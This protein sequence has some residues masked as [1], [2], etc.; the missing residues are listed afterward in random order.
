MGVRLKISLERKQKSSGDP[1]E[2]MKLKLMKNA[3]AG[4]GSLLLMFTLSG[5]TAWAVTGGEVDQNNAYPNV[6]AVVLTPP[7]AAVPMAVGSGTLIHPRVVLTAGHV[8]KMM[9]W[10]PWSVPLTYVSFAPNALNPDSWLEIEAAYTHP[11]FVYHVSASDSVNDVGVIILKRPVYG[12]PLAN[13][14]YAGF[15]DDLK[16]AKLLRQPGQ[17]GVPFRV[18]GYGGSLTFPPPV[19]VFPGD[20]WRRF[21]DSDLI[22]V[23]P[24]WVHLLQNPATGNGATQAGDSGGPTFWIQPDGTRVLVAVASWG[25]L[26]Q[27]AMSYCWRTDIPVTLDFIQSVLQTVGQ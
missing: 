27:I 7:V 5:S 16:R 26:N 20:G 8:T 4:I 18:V 17:S 3:C 21:A 19:V 6:G 13:L 23:L 22:N 11:K 14:P 24:S 15:L 10:L 12:V 1:V 9:E 25:D 2:I